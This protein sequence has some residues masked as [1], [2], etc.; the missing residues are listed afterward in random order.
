MITAANG[1]AVFLVVALSLIIYAYAAVCLQFIAQKTSQG[2]AP[3]W[4]GFLLQTCF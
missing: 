1:I 2:P 3:G 4:H